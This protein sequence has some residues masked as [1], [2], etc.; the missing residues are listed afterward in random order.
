MGWHIEYGYSWLASFSTID[1][2]MVV[3]CRIKLPLAT[4]RVKTIDEPSTTS[5]EIY[6]RGLFLSEEIDF[7]VRR[8]LEAI[9]GKV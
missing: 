5:S 9:S 8:F 7:R 6:S 3:D 4:L 1:L 2:H